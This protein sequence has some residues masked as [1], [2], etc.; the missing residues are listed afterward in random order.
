ME[1][2]SSNF[3]LR[4]FSLDTEGVELLLALLALH[5]STA[6][7]DPSRIS[8][9]WIEALR[10]LFPLSVWLCA[11]V[12][13][14]ALLGGAA[15][16]SISRNDSRFV[17]L[18]MVGAAG[19]FVFYACFAYAQSLAG[20]S[21]YLVKLYPALAFVAFWIYLSLYLEKHPPKGT[22]AVKN[23]SS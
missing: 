16:Y 5:H 15:L 17:S 4:L 13:G 20:A 8:T 10:A 1:T 18:R 12:A 9:A 3:L 23:G 6:P 19:V 14:S 21:W 2:R 7:L 11:G 22:K